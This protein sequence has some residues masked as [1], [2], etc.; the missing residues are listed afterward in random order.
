MAQKGISWKTSFEARVA[1]SVLYFNEGKE[2]PLRAYNHWRE[3][4]GWPELDP[5]ARRRLM[6]DCEHTA[7]R[8]SAQP[9]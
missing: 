2:W 9:S 4:L 8:L 1:C 6:A 7:K 3:E 5:E